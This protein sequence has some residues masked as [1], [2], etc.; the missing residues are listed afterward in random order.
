MKRISKSKKNKTFQHQIPKRNFIQQQDQIPKSDEIFSSLEVKLT[1]ELI[2]RGLIKSFHEIKEMDR[3]II[4]E[5]NFSYIMEDDLTLNTELRMHIPFITDGVMVFDT[6]HETL[7]YHFT[8]TEIRMEEGY[9]KLNVDIY[10]FYNDLF[11]KV[12]YF[13]CILNENKNGKVVCT[14]TKGKH[15][16][17]YYY[18]LINDKNGDKFKLTNL[19]ELVFKNKYTDFLLYLNSKHS[20]EYNSRPDLMH[21]FSICMVY[22][23]N[24]IEKQCM[25]NNKNNSKRESTNH[26]HVIKRAE[27]KNNT[28][29]DRIIIINGIKIQ[30]GKNSQIKTRQGNVIINRHT[31]V[32]SVVGH[33]RHYK[34]GKTVYVQPYKKGPGRNKEE[35]GKTIYKLKTNE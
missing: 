7:Y 14:F 30:K 31:Q 10:S 2:D 20:N 28:V 13:E 24:C 17:H 12:I 4:N 15:D 22:L 26:G 19:E 25:N 29:K 6:K 23:N 9:I 16:F 5:E 27:S 1:K 32:W 11:S 8:V 35:V 21:A 34:N 33:V 18:E 3:I